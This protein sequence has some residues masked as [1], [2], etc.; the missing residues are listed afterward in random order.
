M[1]LEAGSLMHDVFSVLN[2]LQVGIKQKYVAHMHHHGAELF[3][4]D[5]WDNM[6]NSAKFDP[7]KTLNQQVQAIE[8]ICFACIATSDFYDDPDDKNRTISNIE[9]CTLALIEHFLSALQDFDIQITDPIEFSRPIGIEK[10]LDCVFHFKHNYETI[11]MLRC[12]GLADAVYQNKETGAIALAEYKTTSMLNQGWTNAFG[13]RHQLTLY[14]ALLQGYFGRQQNFNTIVVGSAIPVRS[15]SNPVQH[16]MVPR[17]QEHIS[18]MLNTFVYAREM[19]RATE[20]APL[21]APTFTH[22]CNRYFR[23]CALMDLCTASQEDQAVML[24]GMVVA[25]E[26]SPS[27]ERAFLRNM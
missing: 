26:R 8:K 17:D 6:W 25:D 13:M 3:P 12:I 21:M 11:D 19:I 15:T 9:L 23:T 27:E 22:S 1:A 10:S 7:K 16:F 24:D 18:A 2:L 20:E 14:N 4:D 5:R